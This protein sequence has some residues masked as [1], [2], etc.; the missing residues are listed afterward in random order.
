MLWSHRLLSGPRCVIYIPRILSVPAC[1]PTISAFVSQRIWLWLTA[2]ASAVFYAY[3]DWRFLFL[4]YYVSLVSW[5]CGRKIAQ[6]Q[7]ERERKFFVTMSIVSCLAVLGVFKYFDFF[8][9]TFV[10]MTAA[11]GLPLGLHVAKFVLPVG[12]SFYTFHALSYTIDIYRRK[13][14]KPADLLSVAVYLSFFP[15]LVAG[16]IVRAHRFL[17]PDCARPYFLASKDQDW[18]AHHYLGL[19]LEDHC[20]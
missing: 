2:V 13:L 8:T 6:G 14:A 19:L 4:L 18:V 15:Q 17:P 9:T 7:T 1:L 11:F 16:P 10:S 5:F 3:W 12:I 20:R